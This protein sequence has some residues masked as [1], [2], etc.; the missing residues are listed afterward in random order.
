MWDVGGERLVGTGY[1]GSLLKPP[2]LSAT[3]AAKTAW[4]L[5]SA[6]CDKSL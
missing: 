6:S 5:Q 4:T 1:A 2:T 3:G